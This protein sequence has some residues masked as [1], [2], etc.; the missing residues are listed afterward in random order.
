MKNS[1]VG[2]IL[3]TVK[4]IFNMSI[5]VLIWIAVIG[6]LLMA[7]ARLITGLTASRLIHAVDQ[8]PSARVAIVFGA[9]LQRDGSPSPVLRDRVE[10][11]VQLYQAGKVEKLL[12]SGDNRFIDY[13]EPGA[14]RAFAV[15]LG[16]PEEDIVLDYAGRRTYDTCY[17]AKYIFQ[18]NEA[19]LVTQSYHLP[20][21]LFICSGVGIDAVGVSADLRTYVN[22]SLVSWNLRELPA[23]LVALWEVWVTHPLPV[24]GDVEPIFPDE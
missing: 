12:M 24:M 18:V 14:M 13:N 22:S 2:T 21:A 5:Y 16:V 4:K 20:R 7:T 11:A 23:S 8:E 10:A 1:I 3:A 17:R 15:G 6:L 9:G 19:I